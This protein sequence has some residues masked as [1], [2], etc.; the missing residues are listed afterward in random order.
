MG[1]KVTVRE[2]SCE[3]CAYRYPVGLTVACPLWEDRKDKDYIPLWSQWCKYWQP[4][5]QEG[6]WCCE[7]Y[8][9]FTRDFINA[10]LTLSFCPFCGKKLHADV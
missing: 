3:T 10:G 5:K 7:K 9:L 4:K 8:R 1:Y 6:E 2:K